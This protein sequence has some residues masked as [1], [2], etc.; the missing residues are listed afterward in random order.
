[1]FYCSDSRYDRIQYECLR[2]IKAIMNNTVGLKQ[3]FEQK[4]AFAMVARSFIPSK[5]A[6]MLEA[7][8]LLAAVCLIPPNGHDRVLEAV[9][10]Y[11]EINGTERFQPIIQGLQVINNTPLRVRTIYFNL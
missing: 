5:P 3:V 2:C 7:V 8:K 1:M 9:T 11:A 6:I 4:E 10:L